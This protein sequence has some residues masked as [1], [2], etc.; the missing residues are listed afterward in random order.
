MEEKIELSDDISRGSDPL[1]LPE[2]CEM[3]GT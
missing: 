3:K 1:E 2:R